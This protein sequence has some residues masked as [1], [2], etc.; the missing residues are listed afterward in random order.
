MHDF[1]VRIVEKCPQTITL[2]WN[3][4]MADAGVDD[5]PGSTMRTS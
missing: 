3:F 1:E 2:L 5:A 4:V